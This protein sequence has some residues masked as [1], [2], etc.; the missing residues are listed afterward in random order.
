M[1]TRQPAE[2]RAREGGLR[3][4][5]MERD[6]VIAHGIS[7]FTKERFMECSDLFRCYSCREC[8][9]IIAVT[10]K[11]GFGTVKAVVIQQILVLLRFLTLISCY[12]K[13]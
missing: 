6:C 8:G 5:E 11:K 10:P 12:F 2:G 9:S 13:S 3:F 7:E 1:L 4:G